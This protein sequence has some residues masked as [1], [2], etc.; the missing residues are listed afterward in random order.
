MM[1]SSQFGNQ[2]YGMGNWYIDTMQ[3]TIPDHFHLHIRRVDYDSHIPMFRT[4]D[5]VAIDSI[6]VG[7]IGSMG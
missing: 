7:E 3:R 1:I 5:P 6:K 2:F 4:F